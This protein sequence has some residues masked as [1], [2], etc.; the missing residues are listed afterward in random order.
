MNDLQTDTDQKAKQE[1]LDALHA[2]LDLV[3][4]NSLLALQIKQALAKAE[5]LFN[6]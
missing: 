4:R 1:I 6:I 2:A 3:E 5:G